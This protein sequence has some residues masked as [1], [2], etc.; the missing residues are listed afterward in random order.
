MLTRLVFRKLDRILDENK[1]AAF[2]CRFY[3]VLADDS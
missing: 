3:L 2:I 1:T